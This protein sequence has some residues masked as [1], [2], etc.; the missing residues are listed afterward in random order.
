MVYDGLLSTLTALGVNVFN[1]KRDLAGTQVSKEEMVAHAQGSKVVLALISANY[2][3]SKWC[4]IEL[5]GAAKGGVPVVPVF[6]SSSIT[7]GDV[8]KMIGP[9]TKGTTKDGVAT[10]RAGAIAFAENLIDVSNA[11]HVEQCTR[12]LKEKIVASPSTQNCRTP[13]HLLYGESDGL[14]KTLLIVGIRPFII[15]SH[16]HGSVWRGPRTRS[17]ATQAS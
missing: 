17:R 11:D 16:R 5:E 8:K 4:R 15:E 2:F 13:E 1:S 12:D 7:S 6:S 14:L 10:V 9:V 3:A